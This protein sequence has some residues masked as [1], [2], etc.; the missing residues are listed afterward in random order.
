[1]QQSRGI[2]GRGLPSLRGEGEGRLGRGDSIQDV[3]NYIYNIYIYIYI[4]ILYIF[5]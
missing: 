5:P 1:M 2:W 3:N 4:Y